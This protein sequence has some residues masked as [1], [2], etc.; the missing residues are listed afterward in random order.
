M[1]TVNKNDGAVI[2]EFPVVSTLTDCDNTNI[3]P[4]TQKRLEFLKQRA[5]ITGY[6]EGI[7][8]AQLEMNHQKESLQNDSEVIQSI[9]E[10]FQKPLLELESHAYDMIVKLA[11]VLAKHIIR[12]EIT[13]EQ[14]HIIGIVRDAIKMLPD[15]GMPLRI[16]L[17]P[18]DLN[19]VKNNLHIQSDDVSCIQIL[20]DPSITPCGC[21]ITTELSLIDAT[22][23]QRFS[24]LLT[25]IMDGDKKND[26]Q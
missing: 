14:E 1:S 11:V 20:E 9:I 8:Q 7:K 4:T 17:N 5:Y 19:S 3:G 2:W 13:M 26:N 15:N 10:L 24:K 18:D 21:K 22:V 25:E 12:R 23:E 16:H 6:E